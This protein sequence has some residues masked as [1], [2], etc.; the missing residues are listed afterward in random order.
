LLLCN[1]SGKKLMVDRGGG[2]TSSAGETYRLTAARSTV[3]HSCIH[4]NSFLK[5]TWAT[6]MTADWNYSG[7][8]AGS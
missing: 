2:R 3:T 4:S 5:R 1:I 7:P 6:C 8:E